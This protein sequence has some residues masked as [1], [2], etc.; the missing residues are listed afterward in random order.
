MTGT[1]YASLT[2]CLAPVAQQTGIRPLDGDP[3]FQTAGLANALLFDEGQVT[4]VLRENAGHKLVTEDEAARLEDQLRQAIEAAKPEELATERDIC[5][6]LYTPKRF[7]AG[8]VTAVQPDA[9][10]L[11]RAVLLDAR[12]SVRSQAMGNRAVT[13]VTRLQWALLVELFRSEDLLRQALEPLRSDAHEELA[14]AIA[15]ADRYLGGWRP[16]EWDRL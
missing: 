15:L 8:G 10:E 4:L 5:R 6:L 3:A 2:A 16:P 12:S 1:A 9:T 11:A 14:D 13:K 7:T